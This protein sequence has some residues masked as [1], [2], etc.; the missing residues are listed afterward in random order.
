[1]ECIFSVDV[2]DWFHIL[3]ISSTPDIAEWDY[4]PSLIEKNFMRL[5]DI[6]SSKEVNVTCFFLGW[7]AEKYPGLVKKADARGHE[8]ASH[9]YSHKLVY[10][11]APKEFLADA[12]KSKSIIEN[13][14]GHPILGY[15]AAGF[16]VTGATPWFFDKVMEAGYHYDSSIF[17]ASRGHGG[18]KTHKLAPYMI[19]NGPRKLIEFPISV[20]KAFGK[21]ICF[22][23]GGYLR[24][25][26]Y[27]IIEKKATNILK[28]GRPVIFYIHPRE[29]DPSHPRLPM[30]IKRK[31][32]SYVNLKTTEYKISKIFSRFSITTFEQ[33]ISKHETHFGGEYAP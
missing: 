8:I 4:L 12:I 5:L 31:F 30:G 9:G 14:V 29:I 1:M 10:E 19:I 32:K 13:T 17:P 11:L 26:P 16:S 33:F 2:E 21:S 7:I 25:F 6:F 3:D 24:I 20:G 18:I 15:R 23:G 28:D 27:F 22:F